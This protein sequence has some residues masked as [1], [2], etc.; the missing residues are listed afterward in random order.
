MLFRSSGRS[1]VSGVEPFDVSDT[2][3]SCSQ[4]IS[5]TCTPFE[6]GS[7]IRHRLLANA[8]NANNQPSVISSSWLQRLHHARLETPGVRQPRSRKP[9][10]GTPLNQQTT[11]C[12]RQCA[13]QTRLFGNGCRYRTC[14]CGNEQGGKTGGKTRIFRKLGTSEASTVNRGDKTH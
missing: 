8:G 1:N 4:Q 10:F 12:R 13:G 11:T 9:I 6:F 2:P 14:A 3:S 7:A 5:S